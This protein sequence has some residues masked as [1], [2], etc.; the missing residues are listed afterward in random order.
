MIEKIEQVAAPSMG[1]WRC[2]AMTVGIMIGSGIF[3]LPTVL[4]PYGSIGILGWCLTGGGTIFI[5]LTLSHLAARTS[6]IGGPYAYAHDA[7][8]DL[9]G[10]LVG[11][12]YWISYV[13]A[14]PAIALS[15]AGY[16]GVLLP[17]FNAHPF[18]QAIAAFAVIWVFTLI[19]ITGVSAASLTQLVIT[20][21]KLIPLF[22]VIALAVV[23]GEPE[24]VPVFNPDEGSLISALAA[25]VLLTMWAYAGFEAATVPAGD[26]I[27][28]KRTI[29]RAVVIGTIMVAITYIASTVAV[30]Y[31]VPPDVLA[32]STSP[33]ADAAIRLGR[34]GP[35]LIAIGA[36]VATA[37]A[38][39][40]NILLTGQ[41]PLAVALDGMAP[42]YFRRR[43]QHGAPQGPLLLSS[44]IGTVLLVFN[45]AEG[46]VAA[47]TF[48]ATLSLVTYLTALAVPVIADIR[49]SWKRARTWALIAVVALVYT[50][51]AMIGAGL[52]VIFW[53][54]VLLALGLPLF[55]WRRI[56]RNV[57]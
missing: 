42:T 35:L 38:L 2:W 11:W 17:V 13:I 27:N 1:F 5:A 49:N 56:S 25:T 3:L 55:Y 47:F 39:N 4:A 37:G 19:N 36:L 30:M 14:I 40:G 54:L 29:P 9:A 8:G 43:N 23:V 53:G 7:F 45:Y 32:K 22:V 20:I 21:L 6:R 41:V 48:L 18:F 50:A 12:G 44:A 24:N 46:L 57:G 10:Y 33:F 26:V 52:T 16:L 15:F 31:L 28:P 34:W 51:F